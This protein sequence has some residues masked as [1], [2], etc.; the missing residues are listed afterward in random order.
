MVPGGLLRHYHSPSLALDDCCYFLVG[1]GWSLLFPH[2]LW[3]DVV[4]S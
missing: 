3:M 4:L 2:R 1:L